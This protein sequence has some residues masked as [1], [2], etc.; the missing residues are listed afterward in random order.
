MHGIKKTSRV[1]DKI[2]IVEYTI[3][4]S[5]ALATLRLLLQQTNESESTNFAMFFFTFFGYY[6]YC[7]VLF[8]CLDGRHSQTKAEESATFVHFGAK[9]ASEINQTVCV[10]AMLCWPSQTYQHIRTAKPS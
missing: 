3:R 7:L 2:G 5:N 8:L 1:T 4:S 6:Y 9:I 10:L